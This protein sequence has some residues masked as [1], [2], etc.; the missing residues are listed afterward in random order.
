VATVSVSHEGARG[1]GYRK[2]GGLYLV[3]GALSEPCPKLPVEMTTCPTCGAGVKQARG[4]TWITPDPLLDPGPHGSKAHASVCPLGTAVD[5]SEG[6]KA[7]LIWIG[8]KFYATPRE[9]SVEA[10]AMGV[11]RRISVV[12][13]DLV[14]GETWVAL[15]HPK[16]CDTHECEHGVKTISGAECEDCPDGLPVA[17]INPGVFTMFLPTGIEY[18][19]K[20]DETEEELDRLE[21][22]GFKLVR[23]VK[24][25]EPTS[26]DELDDEAA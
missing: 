14:L 16:A 19:V 8:E 18:I 12:P 1:C 2:G 21:E 5:W 7:G 20:G 4:F 17:V 13:K 10:A 23:V 24:V 6:R 3:S 11:S 26:F 22:R 25:G 9:F 15:A